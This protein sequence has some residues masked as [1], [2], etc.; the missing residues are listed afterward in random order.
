[1]SAKCRGVEVAIVDAGRLTCPCPIC[2]LNINSRPPNAQRVMRADGDAQHWGEFSRRGW[3][4]SFA[5]K[6]LSREAASRSGNLRGVQGPGRAD[7][8]RGGGACR[9]ESGVSRV[10]W[11]FAHSGQT[12][13]PL[14][15]A[16]GGHVHFVHD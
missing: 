4:M 16:R 8:V 9:G 15:S 2:P 14:N 5:E 12:H 7:V 13:L 11:Y 3:N 1:M 10:L 6:R